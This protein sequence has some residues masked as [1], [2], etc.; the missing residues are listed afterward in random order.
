MLAVKANVSIS[1]QDSML[2]I[3]SLEVNM[4]VSILTQD[5]ALVLEVKTNVSISSQNNTLVL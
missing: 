2:N 4:N 3:L 5:N 1:S